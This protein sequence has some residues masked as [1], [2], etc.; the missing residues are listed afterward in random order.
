[1]GG[2]VLDVFAMSKSSKSQLKIDSGA[3][4]VKSKVRNQE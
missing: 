3:V 1:V 4:E 2:E